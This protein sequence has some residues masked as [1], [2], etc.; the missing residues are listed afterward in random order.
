MN[1][2]CLSFLLTKKKFLIFLEIILTN[3]HKSKKIY[4]MLKILIGQTFSKIG[5]NVSDLS[6]IFYYS[7]RNVNNGI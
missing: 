7:G 6:G 4:L 3:L 1:M 5:L 2:V